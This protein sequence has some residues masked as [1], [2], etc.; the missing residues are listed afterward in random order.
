MISSLSIFSLCSRWI[1][2]VARKTWIRAPFGM[3]QGLATPIDVGLAAAGQPADGRAADIAGDLADRLES[4][5]EAIGK[6]ASITS[7]PSSTRA[8]ATSIFS[9]RFMLA[10]GDCSPSRSVVSKM[11]MCRDL[12]GLELCHE[13][14]ILENGERG[15]IGLEETKQECRP[16]VGPGNTSHALEGATHL[17]F[18]LPSGVSQQ[19]R[20]PHFFQGGSSRSLS[21]WER[22]RVRAES[23][24]GNSFL[25]DLHSQSLSK[26]DQF[27][28]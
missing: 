18:P 20:S 17:R 11:T 3:S 15:V 13:I 28:L 8:W 4:P 22:V 24:Y 12:H 21:L 26:S 6:P 23:R 1:G 14:E 9:A 5:G 27:S 7:T 10:P 16:L 19:T 25:V 2:L